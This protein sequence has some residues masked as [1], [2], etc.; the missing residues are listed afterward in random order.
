MTSSVIDESVISVARARMRRAR[1]MACLVAVSSLT[2]AGRTFK[3]SQ[4][5]ELVPKI[6]RGGQPGLLVHR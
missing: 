3:S 2:E 6:N 4:T 5:S 1:K